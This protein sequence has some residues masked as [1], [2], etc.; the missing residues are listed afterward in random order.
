MRLPNGSEKSPE[1]NYDAGTAAM[2]PMTTEA[3]EREPG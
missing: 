2:V 1:T 3:A